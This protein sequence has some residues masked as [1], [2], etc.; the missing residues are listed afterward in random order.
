M[1]V[2]VEPLQSCVEMLKQGFE[3]GLFVGIPIIAFANAVHYLQKSLLSGMDLVVL[4]RET[5]YILRLVE[6]YNMSIYT[7]YLTS[8][9]ETIV[10]LLDDDGPGSAGTSEGDE[11]QVREFT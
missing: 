5:D 9:N 2:H 10:F 3:I 11:S 1:A 7:M 4:K 8:F 6:Q